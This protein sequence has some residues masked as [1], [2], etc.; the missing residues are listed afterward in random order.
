VVVNY[1]GAV[2]GREREGDRGDD[3]GG[4]SGSGDSGSSG[5]GGSGGGGETAC[6]GYI[7]FLR[8]RFARTRAAEEP[9]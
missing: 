7:R 3:E 8:P 2:M 5:G 6:D 1:D 9:G 4:G